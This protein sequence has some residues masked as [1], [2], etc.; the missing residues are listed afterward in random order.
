MAS[1]NQIPQFGTRFSD[2][3]YVSRPSAY[4]VLRNDDGFVAIVHTPVGVFLPGGGQRPGESPELA[5]VR[6][7]AEECGLR[8]GIEACVGVADQFVHAESEGAFFAKRSTFYR[9]RVVGSAAASELDH[10]LAWLPAAEAEQRLSHGSHRWAIAEER[11]LTRRS[12]D[13]QQFGAIDPW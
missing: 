9:A 12:A 13:R 8:A 4:V 7:V 10:E 1:A 5:A 3:D 2:R 11:R 6:E